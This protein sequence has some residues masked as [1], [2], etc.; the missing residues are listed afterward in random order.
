MIDDP[1]EILSEK[2]FSK[3]SPMEALNALRG[4]VLGKILCA[5]DEIKFLKRELEIV[6]ILAGIYTRDLGEKGDRGITGVTEK[7]SRLRKSNRS[8]RA[9]VKALKKMFGVKGKV[10][11]E[12]FSEAET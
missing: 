7:I 12:D 1:E 9:Y 3:L 8:L 10:K 4:I 5:E 6:D 11:D 2:R